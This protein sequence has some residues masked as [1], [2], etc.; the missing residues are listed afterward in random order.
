MLVIFFLTEN[1]LLPMVLVDE[2]TVLMFIFMIVNIAIYFIGRKWHV[3]HKE[4]QEIQ[5]KEKMKISQHF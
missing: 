2:F 4:E 1:I 5:N 3:E